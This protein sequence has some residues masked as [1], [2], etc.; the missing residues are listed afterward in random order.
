MKL[1]II[2]GTGT[3]SSP[4]T[5]LALEAGHQVTLLNR[6]NRS[7]P[8]G[9]EHIKADR[10]DMKALHSALSH[11]RF[12]ATIDMMAFEPEQLE[13]LLH[14]LRDPGHLLFCSTVCALGFDWQEWPVAEAAPFRP[15][16]DYG[17]GKAS[18]EQW[19]R[20][21]A[22]KNNL[23]YTILRPSTTYDHQTGLLRQVC[24]DGYRWLGAIRAGHPLL[25]AD[26][27]M[28]LNQFLHADDCGRAFFQVLNNAVCYGKTYHVV[29]PV[30]S[31]E[32]HHRTAMQALGRSVDLV[33]IPTEK[34]IEEHPENP[35]F[36]DIFQY[37][38]IFSGT[39]LENDISFFPKISLPGGM[40]QVI[41]KLD[42][43]GRIPREYRPEPWEAKLLGPN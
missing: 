5:R 36:R 3:I 31:W 37:H 14:T 39:A 25:I 38:G 22:E 10:N 43:I 19:L 15:N 23:A 35:I 13:M 6:G 1:L 26:R 4:I 41:E 33:S 24:L 17:R 27:G 12:D 21:F 29:G 18:A 2:G 28:G 30:T 9:A 16:S 32:N 34:L 42:S 7:M 11:R 40:K 20:N 8:A